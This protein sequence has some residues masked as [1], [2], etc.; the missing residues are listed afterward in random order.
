VVLA[1]VVVAWSSAIVGGS[2]VLAATGGSSS[3]DLTLLQAAALQLFGWVGFLGVPL[4]AARRWGGA[5]PVLGWDVRAVDIPIG[6]ACGVLTQ[7]AIWLVIYW[8]L[9]QLVDG[10]D[11]AEEAQEVVDRGEGF[12]VVVVVLLAV[13]G[14]PLVEEIFFRGLAQRVFLARMAAPLAIGLTAAIFGVTHLQPLQLPGLVVFGIVAG[15]LA[16]R[17]DRLA[18]AIAAHVGFNAT[19]MAVLLA[20]R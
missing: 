8:P 12:G 6:L 16:A 2:I 13:V 4:W 11:A 19:A 15:V 3:D 14:A 5:G 20:S 18:P 10:L 7:V 9:E 17:A 1:G